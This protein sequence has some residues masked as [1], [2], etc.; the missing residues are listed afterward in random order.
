[1]SK[2]SLKY[3]IMEYIEKWKLKYFENSVLKA[4]RD[5]IY[6]KKSNHIRN[7]PNLVDLVGRLSEALKLNPSTVLVSFGSITPS[8]HSLS[9]I[10]HK[11]I[12][13]WSQLYEVVKVRESSALTSQKL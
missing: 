2:T 3:P 5:K 4:P 9:Q 7:T 11:N 1:M 12:D 6:P 13:E 8:S 10:N